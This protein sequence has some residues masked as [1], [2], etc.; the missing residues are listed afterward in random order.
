MRAMPHSTPWLMMRAEWTL[1]R[2]AR[3][4]QVAQRRRLADIVSYAR[5]HSPLY[6][7]LYHGLPEVVHDVTMLPVTDKPTLMARFDEW[8][9][10]R[11]VTAAAVREFVAQPERVGEWFLGRYTVATT[12]GTVST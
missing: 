1:R 6:R 12:S 5:S 10:D 4:I 11:A 9:T 3:A 8:T 7:E 2:G